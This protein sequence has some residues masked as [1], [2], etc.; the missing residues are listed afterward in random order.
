[1]PIK[2]T[3]LLYTERGK[4]WLSQFSPEDIECAER[5]IASLTLVS[6]TE[7]E[8]NLLSMLE[9]FLVDKVGP[10]AIYAVREVDYGDSFFCS[11]V[12]FDEGKE[13]ID[14]LTRGSD[15]GSESRI[16]NTIRNFCKRHPQNF[17]NHPTVD[18]MREASCRS[19]LFVDDFI[20]SGNRVWKYINSFWREASIVSWHSLKYL[21]FN[22]IAYS[23][24]ESGITN[25]LNHKSKPE[26]KIFRDCPSI[27]QMP[28]KPIHK[29]AVRDLSRKY[30]RYAHKRSNMWGG[31]R[32]TMGT[33]IFEHGCPNNVPAILWGSFESDEAWKPLFPERAVGADESS[34]FPPEVVRDDPVSLLVD[35][36]QKKLAS[37]IPQLQQSYEGELMLLLLALLAKGQR[38][39]STLSYATG[40]SQANCA[41]LIE[42]CIKFGL[43]TISKR[44]T[45]QGLMELNAAKKSGEVKTFSLEIGTDNYY[46]SRLRET[47]YG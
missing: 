16:A 12:F 40:L 46:P 47:S 11:S 42:R 19:I 15:H 30:G 39:T 35:I 5:L 4:R 37:A 8:R 36:G 3:K 7:F 22:V 44:L 23:G 38:K 33:M 9:D 26:V 21:K 41:I 2:N 25:V 20:G 14:S 31:Y 1:M 32:D 6:H 45:K 27:D 24:T 43:I 34:A 13:K 28:W 29:R 17:L 18:E 10:V